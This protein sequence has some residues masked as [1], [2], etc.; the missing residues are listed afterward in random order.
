MSNFLLLY[1]ELEM[2]Y[3]SLF[4]SSNTKTEE[5]ARIRKMR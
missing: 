4:E 2:E 3:R 1:R 5:T